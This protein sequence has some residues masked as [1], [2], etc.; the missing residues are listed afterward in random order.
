MK[1]P[2]PEQVQKHISAAFDSVALINRVI[3][4]PAIDQK[5]DNVERNYQHLELMINKDWFAEGCTEQQVDDINTCITAAK[6]Y[7]A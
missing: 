3:L 5:K 1:T 7:C 4:E 2:T 6:A